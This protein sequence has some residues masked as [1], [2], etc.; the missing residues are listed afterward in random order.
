MFF[1]NHKNLFRLTYGKY[2]TQDT[3]SLMGFDSKNGTEKL[4]IFDIQQTEQHEYPSLGLFSGHLLSESLVLAHFIFLVSQHLEKNIGLSLACKMFD[5][6]HQPL[7]FLL[8]ATSL[9]HITL[10]F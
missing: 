7:I 9:W 8:N 2:V 1:N 4:T 10:G 6:L 5:I 3:A